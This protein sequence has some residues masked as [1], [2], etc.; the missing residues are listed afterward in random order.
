MPDQGLL[1]LLE[2]WFEVRFG[3]PL[4]SLS[5]APVPVFATDNDAGQGAQFAASLGN[6]SVT[7]VKVGESAAVVAE[8]DLVERLRPVV[9]GL[10]PD[11]LFSP[12]G[13]FELA[14]VTLQEGFGVWGPTWLLFGDESTVRPLADDRP[15]QASESDLSDVDRE[16]FWHTHIDGSLA[17][18]A[19]F[20]DD[21]LVALATVGDQGEPVWEIGMEVVADAKGRGLGRA[22][23][24]AAAEWILQNGRVAAASV[25]PFNVPSARTL[26]SVGLRYLMSEIHGVEGPLRVPPQPLGRPYPNAPVYDYYPRWAMNRDIQPRGAAE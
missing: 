18:F 25:G 22:V 13:C 17:R 21:R 7:A 15:V 11:L 9:A 3:V 4:S 6:G 14:R 16:V 8:A 1:T 10:H 5:A 20:E 19:V 23:V 2:T 24:A 26:L 12:F